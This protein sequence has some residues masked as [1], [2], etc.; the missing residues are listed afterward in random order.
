LMSNS[1]PILVVA[2]ICNCNITYFI[3]FGA[4]KLS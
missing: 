2:S 4:I 3:N 1:I